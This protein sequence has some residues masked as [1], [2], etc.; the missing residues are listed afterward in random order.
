M[1]TLG[2]SKGIYQ[3]YIGVIEWLLVEPELLRVIRTSPRM[4]AAS[5][6]REIATHE[7]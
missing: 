3:S 5:E 4:T 6:P 7:M 2:P 1:E